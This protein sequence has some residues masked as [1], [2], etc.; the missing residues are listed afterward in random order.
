VGGDAEMT[1]MSRAT[2]VKAPADKP[3]G[4]DLKQFEQ[5]VTQTGNSN[6]VDLNM[7]NELM[8]Q[9]QTIVGVM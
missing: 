7:I 4:I 3:M 8:D 2:Y 9:H 6:K 5:Q 1:D